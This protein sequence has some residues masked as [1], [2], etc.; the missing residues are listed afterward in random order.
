MDGFHES[1][2]IFI[3]RIA[4][5]I[6]LVTRDAEEDSVTYL[7]VYKTLVITENC[8]PKDGLGLLRKLEYIGAGKSKTSV[9]QKA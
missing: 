5:T 7:H 3:V 2:L 9:K 6:L 8:L 1:S 4:L